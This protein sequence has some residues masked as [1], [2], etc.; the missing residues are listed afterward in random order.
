M[1]DELHPDLDFWGFFSYLAID[2]FSGSLI[3][4]SLRVAA[5]NNKITM[6]IIMGTAAISNSTEHPPEKNPWD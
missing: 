5:D 6:L 4:S 1:L 3:C 2:K